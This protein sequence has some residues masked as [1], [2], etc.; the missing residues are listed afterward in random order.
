MGAGKHNRGLD[1]VNWLSSAFDRNRDRAGSLEAE[2]GNRPGIVLTAALAASAA[3]VY[4]ATSDILVTL[5]YALALIVLLLG[6]IAF[7]RMRAAPESASDGTHDWSV[8][9]AA[10]EGLG[11]EAGEAV[12]ITDR[13][14]RLVCANSAFIDAFGADSSPPALPLER[15]ALEALTRLAR[16]A[17]RDGSGRVD[18]LGA[19][20]RGGEAPWRVMARRAGRGEDHLIWR[21]SRIAAE[22]PA[23][24]ADL[25]LAG[26]F[27][28]MLSR[29][30]IEAAI[31][32]RNRRTRTIAMPATTKYK[33]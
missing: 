11:S 19:N 33:M 23:P 20:A 21:F 7:D 1:K 8:T 5:T 29:S 4:L 32:S 9:V 24:V 28:R 3:I 14:N 18:D 22:T 25:D 10:I 13:A 26:P 31:V 2:G 16:E 6:V 15:R 30:G 17:W 12:A 27:G